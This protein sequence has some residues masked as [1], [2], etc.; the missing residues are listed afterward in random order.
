MDV[1]A[2]DTIGTRRELPLRT[3][4]RLG[5]ERVIELA[6]PKKKGSRAEE[7]WRTHTK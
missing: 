1:N 7:G 5:S 2:L 6:Q 3:Y 4:T